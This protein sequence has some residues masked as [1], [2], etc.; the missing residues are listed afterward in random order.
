MEYK[1]SISTEFLRLIAAAGLCACI[2]F[3]LLG[4][5]SSYFV[6]NY[7]EGDAYVKKKNE[8]Q[9]GELS[10][11]VEKYQISVNDKQQLT[12]WLE[13]H[14]VVSMQV[15]K[16]EV[17]QYDSAYPDLEDTWSVSPD[18]YYGWQT[19]YTIQFADGEA[20][21]F[22]TGYYG[23]Q[24]RIMSMVIRIILA[25]FVFFIII[26]LGIR[27]IIRYIRTL[28]QEIE[29]LKSGDLDYE[30]TISGKNELTDLAIG[31]N[32]MRI[33][34][35]ERMENEAKVMKNHAKLITEM[36]HDL[37]T[38]LTSMLVYTEILKKHAYKDEKQLDYYLQ[39]IETKGMQMKQRTDNLFE[40]AL[41]ESE[42]RRKDSITTIAEAFYERISDMCA[43][44]EE[45][46]FAVNLM[47]DDVNGKQ[48][49][50]IDEDYLDRIFDNMVSNI[51]KYG[52][53]SKAVG[54]TSG[55]EDGFLKLVI[56]NQISR[57][58]TNQESTYIG[59]KNI[60][61]M[62]SSMGGRSET[63]SDNET[64]RIILRFPFLS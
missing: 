44:L 40:Y 36:S 30:I 4:L 63:E 54:I 50:K 48:Q 2:I 41:I 39:K 14:P 12:K 10:K 13:R 3:G 25:V 5:A 59:L 34:L 38:P 56:E 52:D 27:K 57:E 11:Y 23:Y 46:S 37:R 7:F 26:V 29:I 42:V 16:D 45:K 28:S 49:V 17:L 8:E 62:I 33:S 61:S 31:L 53:H 20:D 19:Y 64:F 51:I 9:I 43:Y 6:Q 58:K 15:F 1:H 21:V 32:T 47:L 60:E 22:I 18:D 24:F 35:K 55:I